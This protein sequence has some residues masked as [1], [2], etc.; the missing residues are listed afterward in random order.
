MRKVDEAAAAQAQVGRR[1]GG[2]ARLAGP[3]E[4]ARRR[5]WRVT[6]LTCLLSVA[7]CSGG[8]RRGDERDA[9]PPEPPAETVKYKQV[10]VGNTQACALREDNSVVCW[11]ATEEEIEQGTLDYYYGDGEAPD[12]LFASL[13]ISGG[14]RAGAPVNSASGKVCGIEEDRETICCWGRAAFGRSSA[15]GCVPMLSASQGA[16][17]TSVV[18]GVTHV[19][20]LEDTGLL[21]C[22]DDGGAARSIS[23]VREIVGN[24]YVIDAITEAGEYVR[25][26]L[27]VH[28]CSVEQL[29]ELP[30]ETIPVR[31][32]D[33]ALVEGV[34]GC[35]WSAESG[36]IRCEDSRLRWEPGPNLMDVIGISDTTCAIYSSG[37]VRCE[38]P[39]HYTVDPDGIVDN[40]PPDPPGKFKQ[41]AL[42]PDSAS[43]G[44]GITLD[45]D[46]SCWGS[47]SGQGRWIV[48]RAP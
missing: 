5:R 1:S 27:D 29:F 46:L 43:V 45:D 8:D 40:W 2:R 25:D 41:I 23:N 24:G 6:T 14:P 34:T 9:A 33:P 42:W 12:G 44:C 47:P 26:N 22:V 37:A 28:D 17:F 10:V 21:T 13:S 7:A 48:E 4:G 11:G 31:I 38:T 30:P 36:L 16:A 35:F 18:A 19:C 3:S 20:G 15:R 32:E 39:M